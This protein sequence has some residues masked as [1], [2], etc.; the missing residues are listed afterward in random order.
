MTVAFEKSVSKRSAF[1]NVALVADARLGGVRLDSS[2]M[3]GLYSMPM[4]ASR[5]AWPR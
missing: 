1:M 4:R 2:T 5:R 3:S